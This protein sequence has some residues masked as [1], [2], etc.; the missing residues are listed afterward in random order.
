MK[1]STRKPEKVWVFSYLW[2]P[3]KSKYAEIYQL[4]IPHWKLDEI[5]A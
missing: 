1:N 3:I 5:E 2:S 4:T